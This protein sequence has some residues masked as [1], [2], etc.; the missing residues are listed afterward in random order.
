MAT[1]KASKAG[2][3]VEQDAGE[4]FTVLKWEWTVDRSLVIDKE[5]DEPVNF[6]FTAYITDKGDRYGT[7]ICAR[8]PE[9]IRRKDHKSMGEAQLQVFAWLDRNFKIVEGA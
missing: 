1:L 8:N 5:T 7:T 9:A 2:I 4:M 3:W 6:Y